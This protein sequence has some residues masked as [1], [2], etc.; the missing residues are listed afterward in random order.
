MKISQEYEKKCRFEKFGQIKLNVFKKC[1]KLQKVGQKSRKSVEK[2]E[3]S[4][5][6]QEKIMK[7]H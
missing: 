4:T 1:E 3:N 6:T 2:Y 5:K 7:N